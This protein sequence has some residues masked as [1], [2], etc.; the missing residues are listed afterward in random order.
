MSHIKVE[1]L[2]NIIDS[3]ENFEVK[4]NLLDATY[5]KKDTLFLALALKDILKSPAST[6]SAA[7]SSLYFLF[8]LYR[9]AQPAQH[10]FRKLFAELKSTLPDTNPQVQLIS[11]L[12]ENSTNIVYSFH[13]LIAHCI[14]I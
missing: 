2:L 3:A 13:I 9:N 11:Y 7:L 10:P 14:V 12:S 5:P 8:Y 1:E 4:Q 6:P